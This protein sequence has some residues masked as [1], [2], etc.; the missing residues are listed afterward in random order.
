[1]P[2]Q[3]LQDGPPRSRRS[4]RIGVEP[5][6]SRRSTHRREKNG[7]ER[8]SDGFAEP[9]LVPF[10]YPPDDGGLT[11]GAGTPNGAA[12][13]ARCPVVGKPICYR[14]DCHHYQHGGCV[15]PEAVRGWRKRRSPER[16]PA[17]GT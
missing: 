6:P 12:I 11:D 4:H 10:L 9:N 2:R 1:M 14:A 7:P 16:A 13:P 5:A 15:H 8:P 3:R 17:A